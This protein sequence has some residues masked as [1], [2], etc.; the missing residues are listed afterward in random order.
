[1]L[2]QLIVLAGNAI[3]RAGETA[4]FYR[5]E[6]TRHYANENLLL[7]GQTAKARKG[8]SWNRAREPFKQ[9]DDEWERDRIVSGLSSGEGLIWE[10]RDPIPRIKTDKKTGA[11][12]VAD[13]GVA[14]KRLLVVE[15]EFASVLRMADRQGSILSAVVRDAWD[16]GDLRTLTKTSP[17]R[18]TGAHISLIGH[19]TEDELRRDLNRTEMANGF[20]NRFLIACVRRSRLLPFGGG[21]IDWSDLVPRLRAQ[22]EMARG[23]GEV[24]MDDEA[25]ALWAAV[26]EPLSE[27]KPGLLGAVVA[28]GEAHVVRLALL[29]AIM[30]GGRLIVP[31]HLRAALAVWDYCEASAACLFGETLGDPVADTILQALKKAP[32]GMNRSDL[33]ALFGR[34]QSATAINRALEALKGQRMAACERENTGGRPTERWRAIR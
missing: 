8:T 4:P 31:V 11:E 30:D 22:I 32:A 3:G 7:V 12:A 20:L 17:A 34:H 10:V 15:E 13:A 19:I 33:S 25:R 18:A 26:Y 1:M 28:R 27:G 24:R 6:A 16:K 5:V 14:D 29:Y 2:L 23:L 21:P 9:V